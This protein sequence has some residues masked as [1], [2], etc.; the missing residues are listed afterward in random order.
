[1]K[2]SKE[3]KWM[4]T[5]TEDDCVVIVKS[6]DKTEKTD[7]FLSADTLKRNVENR[8]FIKHKTLKYNGSPVY[9]RKE[10]F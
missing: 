7:M 6:A 5:K 2:A 4:I 3:R 10:D 1:M 8:R 9:V